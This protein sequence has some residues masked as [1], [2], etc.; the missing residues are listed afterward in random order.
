MI[1]S[2]P[3]FCTVIVY[4]SYILFLYTNHLVDH[5]YSNLIIR[6][7][8]VFVFSLLRWTYQFSQA[9]FL[10]VNSMNLLRKNVHLFIIAL[11]L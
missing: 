8:L 6:N 10:F 2:S 11:A 7:E 9:F 5:F 3:V 1:F 4:T